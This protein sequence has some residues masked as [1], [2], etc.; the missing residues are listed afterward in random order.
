MQRGLPGWCTFLRYNRATSSEI[1]DR[2]RYER[3][4][5]W[6]ADVAIHLV[7]SDGYHVFHFLCLEAADPADL[8]TSRRIRIPDYRHSFTLYNRSRRTSQNLR[9]R[10]HPRGWDRAE[11][12]E[13]SDAHSEYHKGKGSMSVYPGQRSL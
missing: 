5:I 7:C 9:L 13:R 12:R 8:H 11:H 3:T 4:A 6:G 1:P 10:G 2:K